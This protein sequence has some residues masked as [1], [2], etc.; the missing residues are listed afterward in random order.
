MFSFLAEGPAD[1]HKLQLSLRSHHLLSHFKPDSR[2][3]FH[4]RVR[5]PFKAYE[6]RRTSKN[7][8][9]AADTYISVPVNFPI[10]TIRSPVGFFLA[11]KIKKTE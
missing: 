9:K 5:A 10:E 6:Q 7:E 2:T 11:S 3:V 1:S 4:A 8:A